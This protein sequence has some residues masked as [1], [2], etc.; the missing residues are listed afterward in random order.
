MEDFQSVKFHFHAHNFSYYSF[1][2]KSEKPIQAVICHLPH[3]TPTEYIYDGLVSL[4]FDISSVKQMTAAR[5]S[6]SDGSTT[7]N[8]PLFLITLTRMT[9][10]QEIFRLQNL[11]HIAIRV[12]AYMLRMVLRSAITAS[13]SAMSGQTANSLPTACGAE[14]VICTRSDPRK[15]I[16]HPPQCAATVSWQKEK[17]PIPQIIGVADM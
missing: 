13:S 4:G 2:P 8:L 12:E 6:P 5:R 16:H 10:S 1:Y 14:A 7:I 17:N 15:G 11:C 9:K 3:N